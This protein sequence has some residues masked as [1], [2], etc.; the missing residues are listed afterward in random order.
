M[1]L[2]Q[3]EMKRDG[4]VIFLFYGLG[5]EHKGYVHCPKLTYSPFSARVWGS[6]QQIRRAFSRASTYGRR[7]AGNIE[8]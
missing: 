2:V 6:V 4:S 8:S 5:V 3:W 1:C 7:Q